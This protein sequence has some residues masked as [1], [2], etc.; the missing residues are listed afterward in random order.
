M[1]AKTFLAAAF[2]SIILNWNIFPQG[3]A[4]I[5]FL[6]LPVS[7][8]SMAMG[9]TGTAIPN[10]DPLAVLYNPAQLGFS[11]RT[12]N[13]SFIFY[14]SKVDWLGFDEFE[15]NSFAINMGYN[16]EDEINFPLSIG[17]GYAKSEMRFGSYQY[18]Q[19]T[20]IPEDSYNAFSLGVGIDYYVQLHAGFTYKDITSQALDFVSLN[21]VNIATLETSV[22]DYGLLLNVPIIKLI[23]DNFFFGQETKLKPDLN[24]LIGYARN[25]V[26]DFVYYIEPTQADPLPR[27]DRLGYGINFGLDLMEDNF[28]INTFKFSFTVEA[29]DVLVGANRIVQDSTTR[30]IGEYQ[31]TLS[32]LKFWKN[33]IE[34]EGDD[35]IISR[36]GLAIDI[37]ETLTIYAGHFSGSGYWDARETS[38]IGIRAKGL[39]KLYAYWANDPVTDFLAEHLDIRYYDIDYFS[40]HEVESNITGLSIH[41]QNITS[42]F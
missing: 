21:N 22:Y 7:P 20:L 28:A 4:A 27:T 41:F 12:N 3:E 30:T 2:L 6:M 15:I 32:D 36:S 1:K 42:L 33:V 25:N 31:S 13:L 11:S 37:F 35:K 14:P 34:I 8:S 5:P 9:G 16:L 26:G 23:D 29:E 10:D 18:N 17:F 38:G 19:Q 24:F 40:G 39:F